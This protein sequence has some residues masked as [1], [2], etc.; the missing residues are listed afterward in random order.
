MDQTDRIQCFV[1][2]V[3]RGSFAAAARELGLTPSAVSKQVRH[4]EDALGATLLH[5]TTRN[6]T[7]SEQGALYFP[8]AQRAVDDLAEAARLLSDTHAT[9]GGILKVNAPMSFGTAW[10][11]GPIA[12]FAKAHPGI[13]MDVDFDDRHVDVIAEGYDVVVRISP[14]EDS[15]LKMQLLGHC[16]ILLCASPDYL[17]HHPPLTHPRDLR[18][19]RGIVYTRH[20]L[21]NE[22]RWQGPDGETGSTRIAADF[23]ANNAEMET[24]A[25]MAGLG[26]SLLPVFAAAEPLRQGKLVQLLPDYETAPQRSIFAL[27]P[28]DRYLSR[29]V[30]LFIDALAACAKDWPW[31]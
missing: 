7:L 24:A 14:P 25:C 2:V 31:E 22:W 4:L 26:I 16:P 21:R 13:R 18:H 20:G 28:P 29:K 8:R 9:P 23:K 3:R 6:V 10:L 5:R 15:S 19:H 30:R 11:S 12:S 17:R 27:Y 1:S